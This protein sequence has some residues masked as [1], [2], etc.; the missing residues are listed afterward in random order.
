MQNG[1]KICKSCYMVTLTLQYLKVQQSYRAT[2]LSLASL[3][4][5]ITPPD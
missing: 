5:D 1:S 3:L 4:D 2:S